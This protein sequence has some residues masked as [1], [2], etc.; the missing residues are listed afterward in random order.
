MSHSVYQPH[1]SPRRGSRV[2]LCHRDLVVWTD[3]LTE[4]IPRMMCHLELDAVTG[5]TGRCSPLFQVTA[6]FTPE[7]TLASTQVRTATLRP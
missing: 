1:R 5:H 4:T 7:R 2:R 3:G 6:R